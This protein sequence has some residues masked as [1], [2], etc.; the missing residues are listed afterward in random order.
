MKTLEALRRLENDLKE[1]NH[2]AGVFITGGFVRDFLRRKRN[3]DLDIV[4]RG[5]TLKA[6]QKILNKYGK[7][8][9]ITIHHVP[10]TDPVNCI[11]FKTPNDTAEAQIALMKGDRAKASL[12]YDSKQRDFTINAMYMP[13]NDISSKSVIDFH[14]GRNDIESR[15]ILS[16]GSAKARFNQSPIRILRAF[17]LAAR[18]KYT[19]TQHVR[20]AIVEKASLLKKVP[21]EAVRAEFEEILLSHKP[22]LYFRLMLKTGVLKVILPELH[23]CAKCTQ[24]KRYH[25]Y[26]VFNHL[27]YTCDHA[28]PDLILRLAGLF[29]DI[30]KPVVKDIHDGKI[31]FY[32]HEVVGAKMAAVILKRLKYDNK[33][34]E[35]VTHLIRLHMYHYTREYTDAGVRRF[36]NNAKIKKEDIE[37]IGEFPLFKLR[38]AE[39]LGNGFKKQP[40]TPRQKD[41]EERLVKIF[42][43]STGLT[44]TD[45]MLNGNDIMEV[46]KLGPSKKVG[47]ILKY[48]LDCVME[49]PELN[50]RKSLL[51]C[52]LDYMENQTGEKKNE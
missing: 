19:I 37:K 5:T 41:F 10:G 51:H 52:A 30:G 33:T 29:H 27:V 8:K 38:S 14:G 26:N 16:V 40:V 4:V 15:Q 31:T 2:S 35:E 45:L 39:R 9:K 46:F 44:I 49:E 3:N 21:A 23:N 11:L 42:N 48:L 34:I 32:K 47:D 7:T 18:T 1:V 50:N 20:E 36:I 17:S 13:I 6:V 25:K 22:S 24:D 12:K 28:E 43:S